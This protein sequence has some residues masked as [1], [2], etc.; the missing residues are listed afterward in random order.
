MISTYFY[1][2][3]CVGSSLRLFTL[4]C[5]LQIVSSFASRLL[6]RASQINPSYWWKKVEH[7]KETFFKDEL[8]QSEVKNGAC[9]VANSQKKWHRRKMCWE[10]EQ[11]HSPPSNH[12]LNSHLKTLRNTPLR[13]N[14]AK[15][16]KEEK[17]TFREHL[18]YSR[19]L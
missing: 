6:H 3:H 11:C 2:V 8:I 18:L 7:K 17:L 15:L 12:L 19:G 16:C 5:N 10:L 14:Q 1:L 4:Q 13:W 9:L